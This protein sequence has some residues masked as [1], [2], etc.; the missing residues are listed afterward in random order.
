MQVPVLWGRPYFA[1]GTSSAVVPGCNG[2]GRSGPGMGSA[3]PE[4]RT[5]GCAAAREAGS[6]TS[7]AHRDRLRD[8]GSSPLAAAARQTPGEVPDPQGCQPVHIK[9]GFSE[10]SLA[11]RMKLVYLLN[12]P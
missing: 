1:H 2:K 6:Q 10:K 4:L 11:E 12:Q 7:P 9:G 8:S 3:E 5:A